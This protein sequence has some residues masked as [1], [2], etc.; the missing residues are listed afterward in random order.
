MDIISPVVAVLRR[1]LSALAVSGLKHNMSAP[2]HNESKGRGAPH[3]L[4]GLKTLNDRGELSENL[5]CLL[6]VLNLSRDKLG[7]VSQRLGCIK[8]LAQLAS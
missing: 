6:V 4:F 2:F 8:N 1:F 7:K 5:I 3:F